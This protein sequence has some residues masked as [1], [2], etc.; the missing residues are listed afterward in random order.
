[1]RA[2]R[3][4]VVENDAVISMAIEAEI[5]AGGHAVAGSFGSGA[6]ALEWLALE[7][8]PDAAVIDLRL[9]DGPCVELARALCRRRVPF[10]VYSGAV[11]SADIDPDLAGAPFIEKPAPSGRLAAVLETLLHSHA[12]AA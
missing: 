5:A 2:K 9:R 10:L 8:P 6:D 1:M 7:R 12:L 11:P 4:L 3:V